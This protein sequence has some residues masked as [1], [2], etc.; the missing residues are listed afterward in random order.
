M[1]AW[2]V[3]ALESDAGLDVVDFL[4]TFYKGKTKL[5]LSDILVAFIVEGFLGQTRA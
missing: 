4:E 3:K 5:V 1:G 2:G